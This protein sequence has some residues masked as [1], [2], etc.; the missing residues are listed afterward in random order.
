MVFEIVMADCSVCKA[1][2]QTRSRITCSDCKNPCHPQCVNMT[3]ADID[4]LVAEKQIWRCPPC[5]KVRRASMKA[6][7]D[8][9]EGTASIAQVIFLLEEAS[10]DRKRMETDFN[11]SF[12][13]VHS[14]I[15]DQKA[16][17]EKQA[18]EIKNYMSMLEDLRQQNVNLNKKVKDLEF[19]LEE[20][21]QYTRSNNI[22]IQG[23]P[24][25]GNEDVY[26][27]VKKVCR[28]LDVNVDRDNIDVCHRL[29]KPR[30]S[31]WPATIIARFVR[32]E[33]KSE[34]LA[35]RRVKRNFS[36]Q[37]LGYEGAAVPI[38]INENLSPVKRK[39]YKAAREIKKSKNFTFL[40]V[41]NGNILM[42]ENQGSP[43][44]RITS[45]EDLEKL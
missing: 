18:E 28:A 17:M 38:Y 6:V 45:M 39:L 7:S 35:K 30:D 40:W 5:S 12:E 34:V 8:A 16:I 11:S 15:D 24:E 23:I 36:T 20:A 1:T 42:R 3:K 10:Q 29:N 14:K 43:V 9:E 25:V 44:V 27:T 41:R 33:V 26:E 13:F 2:V 4:C 31:K 37:H 21:E 32:R 19:R 22:E